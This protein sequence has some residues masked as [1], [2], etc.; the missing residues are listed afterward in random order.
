MNLDN[1][2]HRVFLFLRYHI[3]FSEAPLYRQ[4]NEQFCFFCGMKCKH[5][6]EVSTNGQKYALFCLWFFVI[7]DKYV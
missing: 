4:T 2:E 7:G 6:I 1:T 3:V 5:A